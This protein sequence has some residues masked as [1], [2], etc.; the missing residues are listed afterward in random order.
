MSR[1]KSTRVDLM[2]TRSERGACA[3]SP[4][5]V[6]VGDRDCEPSADSL[7]RWPSFSSSTGI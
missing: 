3:V 5:W 7:E 6:G 1:K 4:F 2:M